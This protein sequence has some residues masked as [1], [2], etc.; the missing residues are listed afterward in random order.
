METK[1]LNAKGKGQVIYDYTNDILLFKIKNRDYD[2]SIDF[3]DNNLSIDIDKEGFITGVQIFDATEVFNLKKGVLQEIKA[4]EF[5][6]KCENNVIT[7][8]LKFVCVLRNKQIERCG[9][10]FIREA[11]DTQINNS[12]ALCTVN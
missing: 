1:H 3:D 10:N 8:Q 7:I 6:S 2:K 4:F 9:Q 11:F 12:E 5:N